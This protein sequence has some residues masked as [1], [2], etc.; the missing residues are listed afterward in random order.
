MPKIEKHLKFT[1][2]HC[3]STYQL[4]KIHEKENNPCQAQCQSQW[5]A[6]LNKHYQDCLILHL[7]QEQA[8]KEATND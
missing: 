3:F 7:A 6:L 5:Q 2:P 4:L 8:Q 1:C